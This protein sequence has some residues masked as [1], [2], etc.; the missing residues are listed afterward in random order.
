MCVLVATRPGPGA[1]ALVGV[2]I[3]DG[4]GR[5]CMGIRKAAGMAS[6]MPEAIA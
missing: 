2:G 5:E 4:G 1:A 6:S 3:D